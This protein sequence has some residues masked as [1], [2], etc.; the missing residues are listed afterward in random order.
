[1]KKYAYEVIWFQNDGTFLTHHLHEGRRSQHLWNVDGFLN[2]KEEISFATLVHFYGTTSLKMGAAS[3]S[4]TFYRIVALKTET[5]KDRIFHIKR[6]CVTSQQTAIHIFPPVGHWLTVKLTSKCRGIQ[7]VIDSDNTS[8]LHR[9]CKLFHASL[10]SAV[11]GRFCQEVSVWW[12]RS[13]MESPTSW[14]TDQWSPLPLPFPPPQKKKT[15]Y[16]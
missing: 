10:S 16:M 1:M 5:S 2:M 14:L 7:P 12:G 15:P 6:C 13:W 3:F 4:E 9:P 8:I 11:R